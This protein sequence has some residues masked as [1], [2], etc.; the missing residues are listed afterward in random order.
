LAN[1]GEPL[2][3][4]VIVGGGTAGWMAAA[5]LS[6]L[7]QN[8]F[9]EIQVIESSE[10]G[11]VGVGEA[12]IPPIL[13]MNRLLGIDED[14]FVRKTKATFKLA[15]QFADWMGDGSRY[16]HP[17]GE[18]G[19]PIGPVPFAHYWRRLRADDPAAAG[20]LADYS[21]TAQAA[22]AGKFQRQYPDSRVRREIAYAFHFDAALYADF[23][24]ERAM[25]QGVSRLDR[26]I[27]GHRLAQDGAVEAVVL[28]SGESVAADLFIDCS[29]F[30]GL[31]IEQALGTGYE[32]WLHWLPCDRAVAMPS[33]V[34]PELP[35]FTR[36][37]A[38]RAGW[39]WRIPLQHRTGNGLVYCSH[40]LGDEEAAKELKANLPTP[41]VGDPRFVRFT[42]GRRKRMWNRNVVALG[43]ASGFLEPL[44]STS[45]HLI[46]SGIEKLLLL[47]PDRGFRQADIDLYNKVTALEFEQVRDLIVFHYHANGRSE[48]F[49]QRCRDAAIPDT[50]RER[51]ELY[52]GYGRVFRRED[53]L[54]SV[55]SWTACFEG[56][57][58]R[59][60]APDPLSLGMPPDHLRSAV[61]QARSTI[62]DY[63]RSMPGHGDFLA[64]CCSGGSVQDRRRAS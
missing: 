34:I 43:L 46:Q 41:A 44:E 57:N 8:R 45:I 59:P 37:T 35:P 47:F 30:R 17:F 56:Q 42:T 55:V 38:R 29:G 4:I 23:L 31:L 13:R 21:L 33:E 54:F 63:A 20:E 53:E 10:I 18:F 64:Q 62:A 5:A 52:R 3:K 40:F 15:I 27:V 12:T 11:I 19:F 1:P 26:K 28:E 6:R 2:R 58:V 32:D 36:S 50:L 25:G 51:I 22:L 24:R 49:W 9:C 39:Q 7:L 14:E 60:V 61:L 16:F 48:P